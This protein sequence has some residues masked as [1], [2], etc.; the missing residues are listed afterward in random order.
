MTKGKSWHGAITIYLSI[1]LSSVIL[2]SGI[3]MDIVRIR[4][5]EVQLRR[6]V[7][8]AAESALAG[9]HTKLKEDY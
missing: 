7:N 5:A 3:L 9:Y 1:I 4:T 2:L 8:T 6:A